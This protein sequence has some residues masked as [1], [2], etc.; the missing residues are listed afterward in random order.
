MG[1]RTG[2]L[3]HVIRLAEQVAARGDQLSALRGQ[4]QPPPDMIEKPNTKL[5][6]EIL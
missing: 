3:Q 1:E 2:M 6:L 4:P 5:G